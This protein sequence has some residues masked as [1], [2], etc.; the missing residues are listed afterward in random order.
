MRVAVEKIVS[1]GSLGSI[2]LGRVTDSDHP[3]QGHK[4]KIRAASKVLLGAPAVGE[5]W[6]VEGALRSTDR[7]GEQIEATSAVRRLPSGK[8][9]R[10]YLAT[11]IPGIGAERAVRLWERFEDELGRVI[12]SEDNIDVIASAIDP[13]R[14][15]MAARL[16]ALIVRSWKEASSETRLL[17]WLMG[18]GVEGLR[19]VRVVSRILGDGAVER[20]QQNPYCLVPLLPWKDVDQ[21]GLRL[22]REAGIEN[23]FADERRL[24]GAADAVVKDTLRDGA[25]AITHADFRAALARKLGLTQESARLTAACDAATRNQA[26]TPGLDLWRAPGAGSMEDEVTRML[27]QLVKGKVQINIPPPDALRMRLN[28]IEG[29]GLR[30][31]PEQTEAV[32]QIIQR[33]VACLQGGAGV[34][35]TFTTRRICDLWEA[36]GGRVE[37]AAL[38]GKAALRLS[39]ATKRVARTLARMLRELQ[40]TRQT[41]ADYADV[42]D[43]VSARS[44]D[45]PTSNGL[46]FDTKT[47]LIIDESSMVDLPTFYR[48]LHEMPTGAH[49]LLVGDECQLPPV[50]FGL[51]FHKLVRD[52]LL[53]CRLTTVHRQAE[54]SRIPLIAQA[55]RDREWPP[56]SPYRGKTEGAFFLEA[57]IGGL[58]NAVREVALEL[59]A[60]DEELLICSAT[61][62]GH[63]GVKRINAEFHAARISEQGLPEIKGHL[64]QWFSPGEPIVHLRNDYKRGLF[65]GSLGRVVRINEQERALTACFDEEVVSFDTAELIDLALAYGIT[66]HKAQGSQALRVI[67]PVYATQLLDPSW[68]YTAVTRAETQVVV[69]GERKHFAE[70]LRRPWAAEKRPVGFQWPLDCHR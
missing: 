5:V 62:E 53:T 54:S 27:Q 13:E 3:R 42:A 34:G 14:P 66:C 57:D 9:I 38:S 19:I 31:H 61:H 67:V 55:I 8:L 63:A 44:H 2:F 40:E 33:P 51:I 59:G 15:V 22:I 47:L 39:R 7:Y 12:S 16:A 45:Q 17:D 36:L 41:L 48:V 58:A 1:E 21:L 70:A 6:D 35:K 49:L 37:L 26:V 24:V 4:V 30:L 68:L 11:H 18:Q 32:L 52:R 23:P 25:T 64:G 65:N 46:L 50:G 69:I 43:S 20:L 60:F 10:A 29:G 56:F 28:A